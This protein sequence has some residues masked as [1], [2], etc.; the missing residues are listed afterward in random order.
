MKPIATTAALILALTSVACS[1]R[2]GLPENETTGTTQAP[3]QTTT[4]TGTT[5]AVTGGTVSALTAYDKEFI[6]AAGMVGLSEVRLSDLARQKAQSAE[7]KQFAERMVTEHARSNQEVTE[8]ATVKGTALA[9]ELD[10]PHQGAFDHLDS[11]SGPA[12]DRAYMQHMVEDHQK[13]VALFQDAAVKANDADVKAWAART[14]PTLQQHL[15]TAR[16]LAAKA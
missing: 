3:S 2:A 16:A 14:L 12:F 11:L 4:A 7:V 6:T 8:L 10:A 5:T 9:A 1:E 13:A 15:Q